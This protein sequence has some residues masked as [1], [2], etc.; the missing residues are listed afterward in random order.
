MGNTGRVRRIPE[1]DEAP[2]PVPAPVS[3]PAPPPRRDS[4]LLAQLR[5][6]LAGLS[7][8]TDDLLLA[9]ILY[10][11]YRESG[12]EELLLILGAMLFL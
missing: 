11:M 9:L 5:G 8:D 3:P 7:P 4:G 1:G 6:K 12:D 2:R 10:L